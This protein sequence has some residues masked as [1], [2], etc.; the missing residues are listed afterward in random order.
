MEDVSLAFKHN[1]KAFFTHNARATAILR[2]LG[3]PSVEVPW[4]L[5][6]RFRRSESWGDYR[7]MDPCLLWALESLRDKFE[8]RNYFN[9][10]CGYELSGHA[11]DSLHYE[12]KAVD[13]HI[14]N[15]SFADAITQMEL[16]LQE[17]NLTNLVGMGIYLNW[18]RPGF[19]LDTRG[20]E[21]RWGCVLISD[22]KTGIPTYNKYIDYDTAKEKV[23][24]EPKFQKRG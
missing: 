23:S 19:H 6:K 15:I 14:S 3:D 7:K 8:P 13:F 21:A 5:L 11:S 20:Y 9:I 4:T 2:S 16:Y 22:T 12:G 1:A 18:K 17:L 10:H 24:T